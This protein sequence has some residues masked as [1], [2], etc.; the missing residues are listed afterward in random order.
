[1]A[2]HFALSWF[3]IGTNQNLCCHIM[4]A[5]SFAL[6]SADGGDVAMQIFV[7]TLTGKTMT[8]DVKVSDTIGNVKATIQN[9]E[10]IS[11][12]RQRLHFAGTRLEDGPTLSDYNIQ[13]ESFLHLKVP[14]A[15]EMQILA[16]TLAGKTI[17]LN[18]EASET[19]DDVNATIQDK[20]DTPPFAQRLICAGE[21]LEDGHTLSCYN[22]QNESTL[23]LASFMRGDGKKQADKRRRSRSR[24]GVGRTDMLVETAASRTAAYVCRCEGRRHGARA[25]KDHPSCLLPAVRHELAE[26]LRRGIQSQDDLAAILLKSKRDRDGSARL[27]ILLNSSGAMVV[28][29][30][31]GDGELRP[32]TPLLAASRS[33]T[34]QNGSDN[35]PV[36][37]LSVCLAVC[38]FV[39]MFACPVCLSVGLSVCLCVC[40]PVC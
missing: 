15:Q 40:L 24:R 20:E 12:E 34:D 25:C 5:S 32:G 26:D 19:I 3:L 8:L 38:L 27:E 22:I 31:G 29:S 28:N 23:H 33:G 1:M 39:C 10:G 11:T 37:C 16:R 13:N 18:V 2:I 21:Q 36:V 4:V 14:Q 6:L 9:K 35:T 7:N 17:T 30:I